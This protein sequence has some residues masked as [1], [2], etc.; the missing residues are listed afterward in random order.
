MD[1][2]SPMLNDPGRMLISGPINQT[3]IPD[4]E[5]N[6][7]IV[8]IY[9]M[10]F[11]MVMFVLTVVDHYP[12]ALT[13]LFIVLVPL[14]FPLSYFLNENVFEFIP[15]DKKWRSSTLKAV[16]VV[17]LATIPSLVFYWSKYLRSKLFGR[18]LTFVLSANIAYT[19]LFDLEVEDLGE[20]QS[21]TC[22]YLR[23]AMVVAMI[24]SLVIRAYTREMTGSDIIYKN[25][26]NP[27]SSVLYTPVSNLWIASYILW[28]LTFALFNLG[29][30]TGIQILIIIYGI[31]Y[32]KLKYATQRT[33]PL[34]F[35][36]EYRLERAYIDATGRREV[37][38][39][40]DAPP[41]A[42]HFGYARALTLGGYFVINP[43]IGMIPY[44]QQTKTSFVPVCTTEMN[45]YHGLILT[46]FLADL[47]AAIR[48]LVD[49]R[50]D[51]QEKKSTDIV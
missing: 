8:I 13:A 11:F 21:L 51:L 40:P 41:I 12:R 18:Y 5:T 26:P 37:N 46:M 36:Y 45:F 38:D 14:G 32:E 7:A 24:L 35:L 22:S 48:S 1:L 43:M 16:L 34:V 25:E 44:V 19:F 20:N 10:H 39:T 3:V 27:Y 4:G 31:G 30:R 28:N 6:F 29:V 15:P 50:A 42:W 9:L 49:I 23:C 2:V 17:Y 33:T 47:V